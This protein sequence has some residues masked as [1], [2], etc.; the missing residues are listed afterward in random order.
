[1]SI[2][3]D[4]SRRVGGRYWSGSWQREYTVLAVHEFDD[5]RT[6]S[7]T[8]QS[9]T[10]TLL[11]NADW[12]VGRACPRCDLAPTRPPAGRKEPSEVD[13][14]NSVNIVA[15]SANWLEDWYRVR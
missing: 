12:V 15:G 14:P 5:W 8:A 2:T 6:R 7:I 10:L 3:P 4:D 11:A 9:Q 1:M 13:F